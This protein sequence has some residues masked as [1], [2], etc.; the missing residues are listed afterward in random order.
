MADAEKVLSIEGGTLVYDISHSFA[1]IKRYRGIGKK[2][3]IPSYIEQ[4]P[5]R[6]IEKKTF[7]SCKSI[8]EIILPETLEEIGD[9]VFAH[10]DHLN[11]L[12]IPKKEIHFGKDIFL[13]CL[14]LKN[15]VITA[16]EDEMV[17]NEKDGIDKMFAHAVIAFHDYYLCDACRAGSYDWL[18]RW[19][20]KLIAYLS[21][22]DYAGFEELWI[23]GEED[24]EGKEYDIDSYPVKKRKSKVRLTFFRLLH[25]KYLEDSN[26][27]IL[28]NY[29][30]QNAS[31]RLASEVWNILKEEHINDITY[32]QVFS[33][34]G[35]IT[36]ENFELFLCDLQ[37]A[38]AQIKGYLLK[39]KEEHFK[40]KDAFSAF[41]LDW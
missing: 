26:K 18:Q 6:K 8:E 2:V 17:Q 1:T 22:D 21:Q 40:T 11:R 34:A 41:D 30:K 14:R 7:L 29:I 32:F 19:D 3:I 31:S 25:S 35:C 9:W 39:Y 15:V 10:A 20:E 23:C 12:S 16:S 27:K 13:G 37:E 4:F 28:Q 5:V 38:N 24:Y 33:E 36:E